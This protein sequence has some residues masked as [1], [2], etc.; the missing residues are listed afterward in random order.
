MHCRH[1]DTEIDDQA[2]ICFKCG[3]ATSDPVHR[4]ADVSPKRSVIRPLLL[5]VAFLGVAGFFVVRAIGGEPTSPVVWLMLVSAGALMAWRL[6]L[7]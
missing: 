3:A 7:R 1:C 6:R 4:P 5:G 2:L